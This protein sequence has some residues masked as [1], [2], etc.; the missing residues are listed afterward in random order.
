MSAMETTANLPWATVWTASSQ[1]PYPAGKP[2]AQPEMGFVFPDPARGACDQSFR[3]VLRPSLWGTHLRLRFSNALG[4]RDLRLAHVHAGLQASSS[5]IVTGTNRPVLFDGRPDVLIP[6][7][8]C[9]WSDAVALEHL[10]PALL[11]GRKLA[12]S[13]HVE[14]ESGPM[15][16]HAKALQTS[17]VSAPHAAPQCADEGE[18]GFPY[19]TASWFFLD[20]VDMRADAPV[21][22]CFGDSITDG[23]GST[24]N[25]DDRWPDVLARRLSRAGVR[26]AVVNQGI[27]ANEIIYPAAYDM[28]QPTDGGPSALERLSRDVIA[29]SGVSTVIWLEGINDFGRG[30]ASVDD[31]IAGVTTGV[32]RIRA[33]VP[34]VRVIAA[35]LTPALGSTIETHGGAQVDAKRRAY[36]DFLRHGGLFDG[37]IDFD[38]PTRDPQT[39]GLHAPMKPGSS[40]GGPGDGLHPNRL[41]YQAMGAAVDLALVAP[42]ASPDACR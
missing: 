33:G 3:M 19:P 42:G 13:F 36:N 8:A 39:G 27:G 35:L 9:V 26:A 28:A 15:T 29:L 17:Y 18:A 40:I 5:A 30:A 2:T 14:G 32:A 7:G 10:A 20:A 24:I 34:G 21:I 1:G 41:G 25:G 31:V 22:V 11:E 6:P 12:V 4:A 23:S 38:A 16:W 37:V